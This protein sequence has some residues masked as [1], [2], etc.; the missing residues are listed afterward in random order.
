MELLSEWEDQNY[1]LP[2]DH[3]H[4][5]MGIYNKLGQAEKAIAFMNSIPKKSKNTINIIQMQTL[6]MYSY[7]RL[8]DS[9][10]AD[11][12]FH[13]TFELYRTYQREKLYFQ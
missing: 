2:E 5:L 1:E 8:G 13:K 3:L 10:K 12:M 7:N 6:A 9:K 4:F 11:E